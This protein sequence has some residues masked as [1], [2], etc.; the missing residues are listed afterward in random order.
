[1][2]CRVV[3]ETAGLPS[4]RLKTSLEH[5]LLLWMNWEVGNEDGGYRKWALL[6]SPVGQSFS[7]P[8]PKFFQ[9]FSFVGLQLTPK[10]FVLVILWQDFTI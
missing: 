3:W 4:R 6:N 5:S 10:M 1:M 8:N 9:G 7:F 2:V